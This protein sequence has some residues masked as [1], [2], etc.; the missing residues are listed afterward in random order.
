VL[1]AEADSIVAGME[2]LKLPDGRDRIVRHG[3]G[4]ASRRSYPIP[5]TGALE[6]IIAHRVDSLKIRQRR[7]DNARCL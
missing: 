3:H 1:I 7:A 2:R 5:P 4:P 6:I